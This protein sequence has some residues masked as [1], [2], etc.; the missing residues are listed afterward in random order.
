MR[1]KW[2]N[3][4]PRLNALWICVELGASRGRP[5][6]AVVGPIIATANSHIG[7]WAYMMNRMRPIPP[8]P[9]IQQINS[10]ISLMFW[11][12]GWISA[13]FFAG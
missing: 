4:N 5:N 12:K 10:R 2:P 6:S 13:S 8:Q 9:V 11:I 1:G 7:M 3:A